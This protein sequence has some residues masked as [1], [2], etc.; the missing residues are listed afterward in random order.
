METV[1]D[2]LN[3]YFSVKDVDI[4]KIQ[5][6]TM[7]NTFESFMRRYKETLGFGSLF[8]YMKTHGTKFNREPLMHCRLQLRTSRGSS[9][10]SSSE[11]FGVEQ[12]FHVALDRLERQI[13]KCQELK[14][15]PKNA[16]NYLKETR[17]PL[18]EL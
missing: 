10:F 3:V 4:N 1:K 14:Y 9:F 6:E 13:L 7:M 8:I 16:R 15:D 17:F 5:Q 18:T 12:I 11:G 2:K